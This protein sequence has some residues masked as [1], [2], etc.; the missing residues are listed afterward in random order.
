MFGF[1]NTTATILHILCYMLQVPPK[2]V[3]MNESKPNLIRKELWK[4]CRFWYLALILYWML[5]I[6][7]IDTSFEC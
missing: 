5:P 2:C 3:L 7:S 4:C 6:P 1:T